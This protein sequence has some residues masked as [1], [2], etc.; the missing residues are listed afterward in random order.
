VFDAAI[1]PGTIGNLA[2]PNRII[3]GS[4]HLGVERAGDG[5]RLGAFYAKRARGGA[6]LIVTGGAA[7]SRVGAGGPGYGLI[8]EDVHAD[9]FARVATA[10]HEARGRIALQLFHAGRYAFRAAFGLQSVAPSAVPSKFSPDP[11]R[12]M[13]EDEIL[14]TIDDF[15]RGAQRAREL[16]YDAIEIMGS[17][18]Y[19]ANQF[20][21]PVTN[22]RDDAWGGDAVRRMRFSLELVRTIRER[23]GKDYPIVFRMSGADLIE[24][25]STQ[26]ET[27]AFARALSSVGAD[28]LNV[29]V[30]WHE[31]PTPT[32]QG[33]VPPGAWIPYAAAIKRNVGTLPVIASNRVNTVELADEI[34]AAG[35][36]DFISMARPFLADAAIVQ[37]SA[38]GRSHLVNICIACNQACIDR[39]IVDEEV[40]CM[41]NPSA[42]HESETSAIP[43]PSRTQRFAVVGGGPAGLEAARVLASLGHLVTLFEA[44]DELGGQFRLARRIPGKS[45]F[46]GTIRYFS[47]ELQRLG[48]TIEL[49]RAIDER[50]LPLLRSFDAVVVSSGVVPRT[51][52]IPGADLPHVVDYA[53]FLRGEHRMHGP[54]AIIGAGGIGVDV[55]RLACDEP[56][57]YDEITLL[58]RG[59]RIGERIGRTT[60]W[61][62][63]QELREHGVRMLTGVTYERILE[64]GVE[65]VD[66]R[67]ERRLV[68]AATV[69][70]AAGQLSNNGLATLLARH[71]IAH[72][73]I[74]GARLATEL[75]A[76]RAFREGMTTAYEL[77]A[78]APALARA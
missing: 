19:L 41:V 30:G 74:G 6:S 52:E 25:S 42:M 67:Q 29:G 31:S 39:S 62:V 20:L 45:D 44:A 43:V 59:K 3:M 71:G 40:S 78:G 73:L 51:I 47:A 8:N 13:S 22:R 58:R 72:R 34:L 26:D 61:V 48:V 5:E 2:L 46:S 16:G 50:D 1:R 77:G 70:V 23:V 21:S 11:P 35:S 32:V 76:V 75:D 60:R 24:G 54:L 4:M 12:A 49:Q 57:R 38:T 10:V 37:K 27:I 65:I 63:L 56:D 9:A 68:P 64:N 7:V 17:E 18:G 14:A 66:A 53:A 33:I 28:A 36:V 15:A 55:A 69:V